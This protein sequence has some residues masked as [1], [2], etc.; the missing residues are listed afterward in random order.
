MPVTHKKLADLDIPEGGLIAAVLRGEHILIPD[1]ST[2]IQ[3]G[4]RVL[5]LSLLSSVP[6]LEA[7]IKNPGSR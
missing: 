2:Q 5:I 7:L 1:G 6:S 4:D 3:D